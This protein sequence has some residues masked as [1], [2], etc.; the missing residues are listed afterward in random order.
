MSPS[1][2]AAEC[3][4]LVRALELARDEYDSMAS[5]LLADRQDDAA[6]AYLDRRDMAARLARRVEAG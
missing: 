5:M 6:R 4:A 3:L 1:F 2:T